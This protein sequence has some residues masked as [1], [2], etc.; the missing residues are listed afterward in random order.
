MKREKNLIINT[1]VL[2]IGKF[3]PKLSNFITLPI[4]T[5]YLSKKEY[6]TYDLITTLIMLV[7]PIATLQIQSAAFRFLID[8]RNNKEKASQII[9]NVWVVVLPISIIGSI[10]V[11]FFFPMYSVTERILISLFFFL[12]SVSITIGQISR[13]IGNNKAYSIAAIIGALIFV[14]SIIV[15]VCCINTGFIT[16]II[17]NILSLLGC[18][19]Y[20][21]K[22]TSAAS[23]FDK[24]QYSTKCI[25]QHLYHY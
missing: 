11:Q 10:I 2:S 6:G 4:L 22:E 7:M 1:A 8:C 25:K 15:G 24:N 16:V 3:L 13:G 20:L 23:Y 18:V 19:F 9:T 21:F 14:I 5:A 17:A 12:D